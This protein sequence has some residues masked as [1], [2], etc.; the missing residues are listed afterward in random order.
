MLFVIT[1]QMDGPK[2]FYAY[3]EIQRKCRFAVHHKIPKLDYNNEWKT[4]G[5]FDGKNLKRIKSILSRNT[6]AHA[7]EGREKE[8][9]ANVNTATILS[10]LSSLCIVK[11]DLKEALLKVITLTKLNFHL[12]RFS[13]VNK[14][15]TFF[16][17]Y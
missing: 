4:F 14:K 11:A 3:P 17:I 10:I 2:R 15:K 8:L 16:K 6:V 13:P 5:N 9:M 1:E 7:K 12:L